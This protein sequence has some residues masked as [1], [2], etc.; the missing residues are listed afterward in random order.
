MEL[1][2]HQKK[3]IEKTVGKIKVTT[4]WSYQFIKEIKEIVKNNNKM[5]LKKVKAKKLKR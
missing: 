1:P 5:E 2:L 4:E 3:S